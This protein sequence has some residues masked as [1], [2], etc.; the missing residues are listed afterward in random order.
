[1]RVWNLNQEK[2]KSK[3]VCVCVSHRCALSLQAGLLHPPR[4]AE[5][6]HVLT[7]VTLSALGPHAGLAAPA[8]GPSAPRPAARPPAQRLTARHPPTSQLHTERER[9]RETGQ[10]QTPVG[11]GLQSSRTSPEPQDSCSW[12]HVRKT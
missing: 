2:R 7:E 5:L 6:L 12:L 9:D 10:N 3:S 11:P 1:M 8:P 4:S